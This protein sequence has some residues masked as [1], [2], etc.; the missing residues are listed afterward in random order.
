LGM[1]SLRGLSGDEWENSRCLSGDVVMDVVVDVGVDSFVVVVRGGS[2]CHRG[3]WKRT[4]FCIIGGLLVF[5]NTHLT[6]VRLGPSIMPDGTYCY[7]S[8]RESDFS[9]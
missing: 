4:D 3:L 9:I 5:F 6:A 2:N 7:S 1:V 8:S